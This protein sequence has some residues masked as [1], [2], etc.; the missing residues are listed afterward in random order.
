MLL[1]ARNST[2]VVTD[3]Q[4]VLDALKI[5]M[6]LFATN[7][8]EGVSTQISVGDLETVASSNKRGVIAS[9]SGR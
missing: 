4:K 1:F 5:S 7:S 2:Y 6:L 8:A 3:K 9:W